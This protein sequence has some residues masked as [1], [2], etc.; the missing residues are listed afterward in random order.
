MQRHVAGL[1]KAPAPT[2]GH[3]FALVLDI[4]G[5]ADTIDYALRITNYEFFITN[6]ELHI[7]LILYPNINNFAIP[8]FPGFITKYN[9]IP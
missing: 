3:G 2:V 8:V 5:S 4:V 1:S 9:H 6:Y 7:I